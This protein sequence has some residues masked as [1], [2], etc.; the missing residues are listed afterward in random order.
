MSGSSMGGWTTLYYLITYPPVAPGEASKIS[1]SVA[2]EEA[3]VAAANAQNG[4]AKHG[5]ASVVKPD[6][7]HEYRPKVAG[8]FVLCPLVEGESARARPAR[9]SSA[10]ILCS[11][12]SR[13]TP[14]RMPSSKPLPRVS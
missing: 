8:A 3:K 9:Q 12:Q 7:Q 13:Q 10:D 11:N 6:P 14:A 1:E 2:R 4:G 5:S